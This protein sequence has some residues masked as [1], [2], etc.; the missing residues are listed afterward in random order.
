MAERSGFV[1]S[2]HIG[3][4]IVLNPD[5]DTA[6]T[7]GDPDA[8]I[9]P[10]SSLKPVQALAVMATGAVLE[11]ERLAVATASHNGSDRHVAVV[12]DILDA[13]RLDERA[14]QCPAVRHAGGEP[15][16]IRMTCSGKHAAML[17]A[18]V[19][20]DWDPGGYLA[21]D[22]P[23]QVRIRELTE[24]LTGAR[25]SSTA[26]DGCGAP[27]FAI[28]LDGLAKAIHR[29]GTSSES[30]PFVLHRNAGALVRAVREHPW[31]IAGEGKPD[32]IIAARLGVFSKFGAEGMAVMVAPDGTTVAVKILDGSERASAVVALRL[33]ELHGAVSAADVAATAAELPL[34]L[35][36]GDAVVGAVRPAF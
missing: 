13:A 17:L 14:L 21:V 15:E 28:S 2:R 3:S 7:L 11:A 24:R 31:A 12:R 5:G 27:V 4:A 25:V 10:R 1:E 19:T 16:R 35:N 6:Q 33:L 29:I 8:M 36:G 9:L 26:V 30:S 23:L 18:C 20:A 32:T 34:S 22:H